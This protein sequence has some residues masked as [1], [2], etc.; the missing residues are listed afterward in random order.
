MK[1]KVLEREPTISCSI[2]PGM[3][4]S[5]RAISI[6]L[7][8]GRKVSA[9]V[10]RRDVIPDRDVKPGKEYRGHVRVFLVEFRNDS[11][12]V[13]LPQPGLTEGPRLKVPKD[14]IETK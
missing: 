11:A 4:S 12:I 14:L 8:D 6:D 7:P 2:S 3:F 13:D 9:F 1:K 10:D 5:E